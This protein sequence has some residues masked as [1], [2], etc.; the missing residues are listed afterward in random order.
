MKNLTFLLLLSSTIVVVRNTITSIILTNTV[1]TEC[2]MTRITPCG[3]LVVIFCVCTCNFTTALTRFDSIQMG[4][5]FTLSE[6]LTRI[7]IESDK[8]VML[9]QGMFNYFQCH[10]ALSPIWK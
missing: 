9:T 4:N 7:Q 1:R 3:S 10:G 5:T 8:L 6:F 2:R